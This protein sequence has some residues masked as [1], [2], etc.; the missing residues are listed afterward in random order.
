MDWVVRSRQDGIC[1]IWRRR[2]EAR[3]FCQVASTGRTTTQPAKVEGTLWATRPSVG[4]VGV[5][6]GLCTRTSSSAPIALPREKKG[7][8]DPRPHTE[9]HWYRGRMPRHFISS[10]IESYVR[11]NS[12]RTGLEVV[13]LFRYD[14]DPAGVK[15][16]S[17]LVLRPV[18][19]DSASAGVVELEEAADDLAE[20]L[21]SGKSLP[22]QY[23]F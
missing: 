3:R 2:S 4:Q 7:R 20:I 11:P 19:S 22:R 6:T 23:V 5:G 1:R 10:W 13:A 16:E 15:G 8:C 14:L 9:A 17:T 12:A 21:A 18:G